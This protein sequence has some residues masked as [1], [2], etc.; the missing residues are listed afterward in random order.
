MIIIVVNAALSAVQVLHSVTCQQQR[1]QDI[2]LLPVP[3]FTC[4]AQL[5]AP[6]VPVV[7]TFNTF[8]L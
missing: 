1:Q 4:K 5:E 8:G 2:F 3:V 6:N 7:P